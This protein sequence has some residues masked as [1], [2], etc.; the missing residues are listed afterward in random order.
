MTLFLPVLGADGYFAS[1]HG[2]IA[3]FDRCSLA[4]RR[5][6]R[7]KTLKPA[8]TYNGYLTVFVYGRGPVKVHRMVLS[9]FS[10]VDISTSLHVHHLNEDRRDNRLS[11]L[12][13]ISKSAHSRHHC[14]VNNP[15]PLARR[16]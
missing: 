3:T 2:E 16:S 7:G 4:N 8:T 1:K 11:N 12:E 13:F 9:A 5:L 15:N 10:D 6:Y 14:T